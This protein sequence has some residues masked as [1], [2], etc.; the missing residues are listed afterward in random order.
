[1]GAFES[2]WSLVKSN[3]NRTAF[4]D[5][6]ESRHPDV[7][8]N[9]G[10]PSAERVGNLGTIDPQAYIYARMAQAKKA[11]RR[12]YG[13]QALRAALGRERGQL[14]NHPLA[15]AMSGRRS[16]DDDFRARPSG[17]WEGDGFHAI[18]EEMPGSVSRVPRP[19][20][21]REPAPPGTPQALLEAIEDEEEQARAY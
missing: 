3:P 5:F 17:D 7:K 12:M 18:D 6:Y 14:R 20:A 8:P 21:I 15:G 16:S 10:Y 13:P 9:E 2:A 19:H 11:L 4:Q 1:M